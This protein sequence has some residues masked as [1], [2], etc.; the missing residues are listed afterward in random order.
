MET[1]ILLCD[2][3]EAI[4]GKLYIMGGGWTI[5]SPGPRNMAVAV[6]INVPWTDANEKHKF[7]LFLQD[8]AGRTI[9][10]GDPPK[11]VMQTGDFELGRPPGVVPGSDLD[12]TAVFGFIGLPLETDNGYRWQLEINGEDSGHASFRTRTN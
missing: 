4:N 7:A 5:C 11:P 9:E 10:L 8:E 3:A 6:R 2:H 1:V 12:F